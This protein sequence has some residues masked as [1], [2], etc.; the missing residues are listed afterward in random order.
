MT[1]PNVPTMAELSDAAAHLRQSAIYL[2]KAAERLTM[3][4]EHLRQGDMDNMIGTYTAD[5]V[6]LRKIAAHIS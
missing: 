4:A 5:A 2:E 3:I 6:V 1:M